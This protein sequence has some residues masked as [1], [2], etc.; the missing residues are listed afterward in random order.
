MSQ[1][2]MASVDGLVLRSMRRTWDLF[3]PSASSV[4][5]VDY[6]IS[7]ATAKMS[8]KVGDG[9]GHVREMPPP[10]ASK[11]NPNPS[12]APDPS[13][14]PPTAKRVKLND[15][16]TESEGGVEIR[17]PHAY[18][19]S[20]VGEESAASPAMLH[21]LG[22]MQHERAQVAA[23]Q[24]RGNAQNTLP[25]VA[26]TS[27][28]SS[29]AASRAPNSAS[30]ALMLRT[31]GA[32]AGGLNVVQP[33]RP[34]WHAPWKLMRVI[35]GHGGW[36]R[37]ASVDVSNEWFV[38][39]SADRTIKVWDLASG[40]LKLTLPGHVAS[41]RAVVV[42]PRH[43]YLFSASEDKEIKCWDLE[44]NRVIRNYHGHLSAVYTLS[45]H[46]SLDVLVSGGRDSSVR[47]WDMRTKKEI[48]LMSGHTDT[49]HMVETQDAEPQ[50]ISGSADSQVRLWDLA[51]GRCRVTLTNHKKAVRALAVH[52]EEY[53]FVSA[54]ADNIKKWKFPEGVFMENLSGHRSIINSMSMNR[55]G[56]LVSAAD[57]GTM[58]FWDY[59]S[60]YKFQDVG[61]IVQ[62]GSLTSEAGIFA[63]TFDHTGSRLITCEADKTIKIWKEDEDA[64]PE[65]HPIDWK[66]NRNKSKF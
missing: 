3:H 53:S 48:H 23:G 37:C 49:V 58:N 64:T 4:P 63:T 21:V 29:A 2:G 56:V 43:P 34:E 59:K 16:V 17:G 50:V 47:V 41:V 10:S 44:Y 46:P 6:D 1:Q 57:N 5:T 54:S 18:P 14:L 24:Q 65:S 15:A 32:G 22:R 28:L 7:V 60:G 45:L 25:V 20:S 13:L 62:P 52:K 36:V 30:Q 40:T 26:S 55:D 35:A 27:L 8:M 9:Y 61:T 19:G 33:V 42:S 11:P 39:G 66:P 38:T 31:G 51:A 12:S